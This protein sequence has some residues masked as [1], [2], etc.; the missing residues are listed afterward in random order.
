MDRR[1]RRTIAVGGFR[2]GWARVIAV[3]VG[4]W[5]KERVLEGC[6]GIGYFLDILE[7]D[8]CR[9]AFGGN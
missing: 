1:T 6:T 8:T 7:C 5:D 2:V 3:D 9:I 4:S